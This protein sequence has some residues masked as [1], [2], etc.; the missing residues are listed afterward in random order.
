MPKGSVSSA[1]ACTTAMMSG[2]AAKIAAATKLRPVIHSGSF[3]GMNVP[4]WDIADEFGNTNI[5]VTNMD[6]GRDLAKSLGE[7][8]VALMRGHGCVVVGRTLREA[9]F[10]SIYLEL[11]AGLQMKAMAM[12]DI[13]FLTPGEV[14]TIIGRTSAF[15]IDRAWEYWCRRAD[16]PVQ[17][18]EAVVGDVGDTRTSYRSNA[19][20]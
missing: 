19:F 2:R 6:Q 14:D 4:V 1:W 8:S 7:N 3:I 12:G 17:E 10:I 11:N 15:T 18:T 9:V 20:S 13:K 16:R 5:L